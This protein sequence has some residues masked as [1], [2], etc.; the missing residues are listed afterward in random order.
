MFQHPMHLKTNITKNDDID[1][2]YPLYG[3][4]QTFSVSQIKTNQHL[5]I[6]LNQKHSRIRT[7]DKY[8]VICRSPSCSHAWQQ[9]QTYYTFL[10]KHGKV[11][12]IHPNSK[13]QIQIVS[14]LTIDKKNKKYLQEY[15]LVNK[16]ISKEMDVNLLH[17]CMM[18]M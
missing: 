7:G 14:F 8:I 17:Q 4:Q 16:N 1:E 6:N 15:R 13:Y 5:N 18:I 3:Y 12:T 9:R 10:K 11:K 2:N